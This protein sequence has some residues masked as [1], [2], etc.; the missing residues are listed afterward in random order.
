MLSETKWNIIGYSKGITIAK[1]QISNVNGLEL[2]L[3]KTKGDVVVVDTWLE[4]HHKSPKV[5]K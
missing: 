4:Y 3:L 5:H 2:L 1:R